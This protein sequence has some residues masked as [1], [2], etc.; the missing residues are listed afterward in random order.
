MYLDARDERQ[1]EVL[2]EYDLTSAEKSLVTWMVEAN[3]SG[4][5]LMKVFMLSGTWGE[6]TYAAT[7]EALRHFPTLSR[8]CSML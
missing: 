4:V 5:S 6:P 8:I 3:A 1:R 2:M 7:V